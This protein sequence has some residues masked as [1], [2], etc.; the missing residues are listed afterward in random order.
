MSS[1]RTAYD[2]EA[3][4][5]VFAEKGLT[6]G[7]T[8]LL[9][10]YMGGHDMRGVPMELYR[11]LAGMLAE[12]GFAVCTNTAD[13]RREPPVPCTVPIMLPHAMMRPFCEKAGCF[14]GIRSGL[15]DIISAARCRKIILYPE[16]DMEGVASYR[17]FFSLRNMGLCDDAVE[18]EI[19]AETE[20]AIL[21]YMLKR[22]K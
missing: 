5:R 3:L 19:T 10:P 12:R 13:E 17:E 6:Q 14:I 7:R 16:I 22:G 18:M 21:S 15:C 9:S 2:H 1:V 11:R 20:R 4:D 8:V